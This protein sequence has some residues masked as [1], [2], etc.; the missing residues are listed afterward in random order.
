MTRVLGLG[1]PASP[2]LAAGVLARL[3]PAR[4][5]IR[6]AG[7]PADE[8][9]ALR[10]ALAQAIA[11]LAA[12]I[13][14]ADTDAADMLSFQLAML[15]DD[16]LSEGAFAAI[17]AG[18]A[19]DSAWC[20]AL[21][22][23][24]ADYRA[25]EDSYFRARASDLEDMRAR[26][27]RALTG[28]AELAIPAGA[29]VLGADLTPSQF[30]AADWRQGGA[31]LLT[32]GS[33]QAHVAM[34]A[35][36]RAVPM[37]IGLGVAP[38]GAR[39]A[40]VDGGTGRVVFDPDLDDRARFTD[41]LAAAQRTAAAH[42]EISRKPAMTAD[43]TMIKVLVNLGDPDE[44]AELDPAICDGVGLVRS[45][46]LF[47]GRD[48]LPDEVAQYQAY[49]RILTWA[50][51]RP[52]TI[53]TLDAG[54][55]K[56]VPGL[57]ID[58]ET[59]PFLGTRGLRLSLA[60]PEVFTQ[61]LRALARAAVVG[62]LRIMLPMVTLPA[63]LSAAA[64]LLDQVVAELA[65]A[66]IPHARPPL[67][68]MVEVPAAA[69]TAGDFGADFYSIGSNDLT[70]YTLAAARDIGSVAR[71]GD[72]GHPAVLQLI[73]ATVAAAVVR[74]VDVSLC[75][76]A[77]GEPGLVPALLTAGLRSLSVAP[78]AVGRTK[79]AIAGVRLP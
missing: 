66:G 70:Q 71:L 25:A 45:E 27:L 14:A 63:E 30:L 2:G 18:E 22:R 39:E 69:L 68:I 24:I 31:I 59:N 35:R 21:D 62:N 10:A 73:R 23:E 26:V 32:E 37:V 60:K 4:P 54:G 7:T 40:L 78:V 55:D 11:D 61:Q 58:A 72:A 47:H 6:H 43:G 53:R 8:A 49:H 75:G 65:A 41:A 77:A 20:D 44:L 19:A 33:A 17:E 42:A 76:D 3:A 36:A 51:P 64:V 12:L 15:E 52:V 9:G 50:A 16:A 74:G 5:T 56:P 28:A 38:E 57:T 29:V 13:G 34:L 46:F 48:G 1:I 67:G 79:A